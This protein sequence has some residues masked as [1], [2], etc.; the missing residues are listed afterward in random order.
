MPDVHPPS[1]SLK[2]NRSSVML[3]ANHYVR[4]P[5][6]VGATSQSY[7]GS[8]PV[9]ATEVPERFE[10]LLRQ[11]TQGRPERY[12][13]LMERI[14][15]E[16]LVPARERHDA[17]EAERQRVAIGQALGWATNALRVLPELAN[18]AAFIRTPELQSSL[19]AL[20]AA[21]SGLAGDVEQTADA[22]TAGSPESELQQLLAAVERSCERIAA[23]MPESRG[24]F[25]RG[26]E[27]EWETVKQVQRL[28]FKTT[29]AIAAL[30]QRTQFR[31]G[32]NWS[33]R[34]DVILGEK[35][36]EMPLPADT[37]LW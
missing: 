36:D 15:R 37:Q 28:W 18:Y 13:A 6:G 11:A 34:R 3:Y 26:H 25:R 35:A 24:V 29:D 14:T 33:K 30:S 31:R 16:V 10:A 9:N 12:L 2:I 20:L 5:E 27:F 4:L 19:A 22:A 21:A 8:F 7:L 32:S 23:L 1:V 17:K